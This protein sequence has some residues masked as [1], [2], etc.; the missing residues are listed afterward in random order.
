MSEENET[1]AGERRQ[2]E[3]KMGGVSGRSDLLMSKT[4]RGKYMNE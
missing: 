2:D 3:V 1:V 4:N